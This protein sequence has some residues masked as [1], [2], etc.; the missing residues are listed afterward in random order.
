MNSTSIIAAAT[1]GSGKRNEDAVG[2]VSSLPYKFLAVADGLGSF[3]MPDIA[4]KTIIQSIQADLPETY[5][6]LDFYAL[7]K[8]AKQS[9]I[10]LEENE[11]HEADEVDQERYGTTLICMAESDSEITLAYVGNGSV[12]HLRGNY[13]QTTGATDVPWGAQN[14]LNPHSV[15]VNGREALY[16]LISDDQDFGK[17]V[18]SII[19]LEKD[20]VEGD[21]LI[22]TTDGID[23]PDQ[24]RIG[25]NDKGTWQRQNTLLISLYDLIHSAS[26]DGLQD[27]QQLKNLL[28]DYL[29]SNKT[30]FM[31]DASL[32]ILLTQPFLNAHNHKEQA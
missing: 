15:N 14:L 20:P 23:S 10:D 13:M 22:I 19:R 25:K 32:G 29:S 18:P 28:E 1:L 3:A 12:W 4:S 5:D 17:A 6:Q 31:D 30:E 27:D 7:F 8:S 9:L 26:T 2:S 16:K 24:R 21:V 11:T